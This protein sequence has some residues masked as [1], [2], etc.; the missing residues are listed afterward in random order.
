[1]AGRPGTRDSRRKK[2]E[3]PRRNMSKNGPK[4][5]LQRRTGRW[6]CGDGKERQAPVVDNRKAAAC[7]K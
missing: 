5:V 1:M 4:T 2:V 3:R 6:K 7:G